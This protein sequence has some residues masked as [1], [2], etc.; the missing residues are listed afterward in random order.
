MRNA[1]AVQKVAYCECET[2]NIMNESFIYRKDDDD[3]T[4]SGQKRDRL[5]ITGHGDVKMTVWGSK[6]ILEKRKKATFFNADFIHLTVENAFFQ[7]EEKEMSNLG[8]TKKSL[9]PFNYIPLNIKWHQIWM[10]H[11]FFVFYF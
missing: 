8:L 10:Y 5:I 3:V 7:N 11:V 1:V 4:S 6:N 9:H 2:V